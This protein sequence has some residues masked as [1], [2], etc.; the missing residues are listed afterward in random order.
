MIGGIT[1]LTCAVGT[2]LLLVGPWLRSP[3]TAWQLGGK[4]QDYEAVRAE[5][6]SEGIFPSSNMPIK[7]MNHSFETNTSSAGGETPGGKR[8]L[9]VSALYPLAKSK[10]SHKDY[11]EWLQ[12][13]LGKIATDV[14][15]YAP[16][17]LENIVLDTFNSRTAVLANSSRH[18]S[19]H[20]PR[21]QPDSQSQFF[22]LNT[23]YGTAF[24]IPPLQGLEKVYDAMH[25]KDRERH[26][27]SHELYAVWNAKPFLLN[28]A[29]QELQKRGRI[30]DYA[31]WVDAG[32]FRE[33]HAFS[34]WPDARR[35][36]EVLEQ[37]EQGEDAIF[38]PIW[39]PPGFRFR[40][41]QEDMGPV[42]DEIS[43][44]PS[45]SLCS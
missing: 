22:T 36:Q 17:S 33:D 15:F 4:V 21:A 39:D 45:A 42:D 29:V 14:Y 7:E 1:F 12:R 44:G 2:Y 3:G 16:P 13:F 25:Q 10:H 28:T 9:L 24:S 19:N 20:L 8:V 37:T 35:V 30:Y 18:G 6:Q 34:E 11:V 23:E 27:H 5:G 26:R 40:T 38:L 43:E 31:F 41:W 32:S